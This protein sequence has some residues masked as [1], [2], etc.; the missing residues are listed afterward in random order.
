MYT[1][2]II[3]LP[4]IWKLGL[5]PKQMKCSNRTISGGIFNQIILF[6]KYYEIYVM[7]NFCKFLDF[8]YSCCRYF[9]YKVHELKM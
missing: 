8:F 6:Q 3:N 1:G 7:G 9:A 2:L 4:L 5:T